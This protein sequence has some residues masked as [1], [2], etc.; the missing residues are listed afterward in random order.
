MLVAPLE[1]SEFLVGAQ[2]TEGGSGANFV[3]HWRGRTGVPMGTVDAQG[4]G[5]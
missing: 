4:E 2:D 3:V 5:G 1:T